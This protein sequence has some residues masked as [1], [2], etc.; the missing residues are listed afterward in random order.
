M[1]KSCSSQHSPSKE[2]P[3]T[4]RR[5]RTKS[6]RDEK[7][8]SALS[9]LHKHS[10]AC[11]THEEGA[12]E[13]CRQPYACPQ[14]LPGLSAALLH[15]QELVNTEANEG[16][17]RDGK[18]LCNLLM[19]QS[20]HTHPTTADGPSSCACSHQALAEL[21]LL[22]H[23]YF[24][25]PFSSCL[26]PL[27]VYFHPSSPPFDLYF[28]FKKTTLCLKYVQPIQSISALPQKSQ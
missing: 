11:T 5:N 19:G 10:P 16:V 15:K 14:L 27:P 18:V 8:D 21:L 4:A 22:L 2:L 13:P 6:Q 9:E 28:F 25:L 12:K 23:C 7:S 17:K 24:I 1:F 20:P 26:F 3:C